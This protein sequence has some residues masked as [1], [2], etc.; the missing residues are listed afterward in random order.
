MKNKDR[1]SALSMKERADLIKLYVS[2]GITSL[3]NIKKDYNSFGDGGDTKTDE[4]SIYIKELEPAVVKPAPYKG[5]LNTYYPIISA[6]PTGHSELDLYDSYGLRVDHISKLLNNHDYDFVTNNCSD[7]TRCAVEQIF[8]EKINPFL[9]TTPGDVQ[10]FVAKKTRQIPVMKDIGQTVLEFNIPFATAMDLKNQNIDYRIRD[11]LYKSEEYKKEQQQ[12]NPNWDSSGFD[13]HV[14][15][16]IE[17]YENQKYKFQPFVDG[18]EIDENGNYI[19][20][21]GGKLNNFGDGGKLL[22]KRK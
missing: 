11:Y 6:Y 10:D 22:T 1:W 16:V 15:K 17:N 19:K 14:K 8:N 7:A 18:Y 4:E 12:E 13:E 3:D 5:I 21:S 9:F 2:N 20:A